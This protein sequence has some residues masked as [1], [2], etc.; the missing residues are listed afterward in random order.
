MAILF[1]SPPDWE[2]DPGAYEFTATISGGIVLN[3]SGEQMGDEGDMF[4]AFDS[5]GNVR[6]LGLM[7]FPPFGPY[8]D[9]PVFEVQLRSND[10]GDILHFKYYDAWGDLEMGTF[11]L[12]DWHYGR[13]FDNDSEE[14]T[15]NVGGPY[16]TSGLAA[17]FAYVFHL[18]LVGFEFKLSVVGRK[19][20]TAPRFHPHQQV[21][22]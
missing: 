9:T 2:D 19:V 18:Q 13:N 15:W 11:S 3:I 16:Y 1:A 22:E 14:I 20:D 7:L 6:G 12:Y 4:A 8:Q 5:D 21:L 17:D 10:A